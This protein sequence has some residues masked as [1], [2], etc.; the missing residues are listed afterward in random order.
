MTEPHNFARGPR[1]GPV[2]DLL[3]WQ[4]EVSRRVADCGKGANLV[5]DKEATTACTDGSTIV[6]PLPPMDATQ[7]DYDVLRG[8]VIHEVGHLHRPDAF[9]I[10]L[11]EKIDMRSKLGM[12][13]NQVE[14]RVQE[15]A[16]AAAHVGDKL[17]LDKLHAILTRRQT[18]KLTTEI[19]T[20]AMDPEH[21][22]VMGKL[23]AALNVGMLG[24]PWMVR[25]EAAIEGTTADIARKFPVYEKTLEDL[26]EE[27]WATK[28]NNPSASAEEVVAIARELCTRLFPDDPNPGKS[29]DGD[30]S[31]DGE[32]GDDGDP[33]EGEGKGTKVVKGVI[34]WH[35][36]LHSHHDEA[37]KGTTAPSSIDWTGITRGSRVPELFREQTLT[38]EFGRSLSPYGREISA[39]MARGGSA[40]PAHLVGEVR[41]KLQAKT[42]CKWRSEQLEGRLDSRNLRRLIMPVVGDGTFNRSVF[43]RKFPGLKLDVSVTLLVDSSGSMSGDKYTMAA[44]AALALNELCQ[45]ALRVP[46]EVI[47]FTHS[48]CDGNP[49]Y[50]VH[51]T[52][53][54]RAMSTQQLASTLG[55]STVYLEGNADAEAVMFAVERIRKQPTARKVVIVLSDGAPADARRG[56]CKQ[57]YDNLKGVV[58]LVRKAGDVELYGIGIMDNNV[59]KFYS[60]TAP[61]INKPQELAPALINVLDDVLQKMPTGGT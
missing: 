55:S 4:Q 61:V 9:K 16:T 43:R 50:Y 42:K 7:E 19:D 27:G 10:P 56:G 6:C 26:L 1:T 5:F 41:R 2:V 40:F 18:A 52:F 13:V 57:A 37:P 8:F 22:E 21:V 47:G 11:R 23:A 34:P 54:Q 38:S 33:E 14:D 29:P 59:R 46:S 49:R 28:I 53:K 36:L 25:T 3:A 48:S 35:L 58:E 31:G 60:K 39:K 32:G 30:D 24:A 51:K 17:S 20:A 15:A 12:L 45:Q 44:T